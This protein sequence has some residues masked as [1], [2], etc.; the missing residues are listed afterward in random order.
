MSGG[1]V[2]LEGLDGVG[3]STQV[4][5]LAAWLEGAGV[6]HLV[7]REPGGTPLGEAIREVVLTR[8]LDV[9]PESE[10]LLMLA[11]RAALVRSVVGPALAAGKVVIADRFALSTLAYQAYGRGLDPDR[12]RPVLDIATGG[13]HPDLYVV[14][15][16]PLQDSAER[17][18]GNASRP[19]RIEREGEGF[20]RKVREAYLAL[21]ERESGVVVLDARGTPEE[22][23][24]RIRGLLSARIA[25]L[26]TT[27]VEGQTQDDE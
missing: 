10:L 16:L 7:V 21:A 27:V 9:G 4:A 19:D 14:L 23:H 12:V 26:A 5:L 17:R 15:D 22:V 2:V 11:A 3:K 20:R 25:A 1:F 8:D 13:L 24:A 18:R 6:P